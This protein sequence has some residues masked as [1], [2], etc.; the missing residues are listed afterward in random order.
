MYDQLITTNRMVNA[1]STA[2]RPATSARR[3][4]QRAPHGIVGEPDDGVR[5]WCTGSKELLLAL[6][7]SMLVMLASRSLLLRPCAKNGASVVS[8]HGG[9]Q[10]GVSDRCARYGRRRLSV[11]LE[12]RYSAHTPL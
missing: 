6:G 3:P 9:A 8:L 1:A 5:E 10:V 12:P 4:V 7:R 2:R 11:P